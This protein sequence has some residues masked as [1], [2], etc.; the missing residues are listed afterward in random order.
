MYIVIKICR[1]F[2]Q[3][4][5]KKANLFQKAATALHILGQ[6]WP[7]FLRKKLGRKG[8]KKTVASQL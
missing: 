3:Q 5:K 6:N 8:P 2:L 7:L 1:A 4:S